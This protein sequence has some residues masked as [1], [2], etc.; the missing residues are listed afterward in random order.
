MSNMRIGG[1]ASG[2]D[3]DQIVGDLMKAERMPLDKLKQQKQV[4]EWQRDDYRSMNS[5][6]LNFRTELTNMKLTTQ[7]RARSVTSTNSELVTATASSAASQSSYTIKNVS[8]LASAATKVSA[9]SIA[10]TGQKV[11]PSKALLSQQGNL[12]GGAGYPWEN[13]SIGNKTFIADGVLDKFTI[14]K[15][16]DELVDLTKISDMTVKVNGKA[17]SIVAGDT[18]TTPA[19]ADQVIIDKNGNLKF[20]GPVAKDAK[21]EFNYVLDKKVEEKTL[22]ADTS[23]WQLGATFI[24]NTNFSL[25]ITKTDGTTTNYTLSGTADGDG[26][27]AL[28]DSGATRI[29][30]V[31][32]ETGKVIFDTAQTSGVTVKASYQQKYTSM[33][34]S[35]ETST[36]QKTEKFLISGSDT[37]NQVMN[38]VNS[39]NVGVTMF[40][41]SYSGN[42][43]LTRSETGN[44]SK[45]NLDNSDTAD[46][47]KATGFFATDLLKLSSAAT[48]GSNAM[49]NINGMNTSRSS[50]AFEM[51][52]V[53]FTLKQTFTDP[54]VSA[55]LSI[56]NDT[57]K[58]FDNIKAFVEKYNELIDKI[59]K[60][61]SEEY[62]RSYKPLTDEQRETL[63]EKQQEQWEE[64]AKSGLLKRDPILTGVL[65]GMRSN[66]YAPVR[67]A[68][69]DP[70]MNQLASIGIKTTANYLEGGKLEINEAALK[71]AIENNPESVENLFRG[72]G[73]TSDEQGIVHRLYDTVNGA[74]DKLK[75]RAGNT[76]STTK[77][78]TLG[79]QLDN[80]DSQINRFES[81]LTQVEDRYWRQFTAMEKAIQK[82]NS[83]SA[84]LMQQFSGG[85]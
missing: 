53:T 10:V 39:S 62:Y 1:L 20:S 66:F 34:L 61:S 58:V 78:F 83:Q 79:R 27:I 14:T 56:S 31:N 68:A 63:S 33:D 9:G 12:A 45:G 16:A 72:T 60:K 26:F 71:K 48:Y 2:M 23:E 44:F 47:I 77:Q 21:I 74:M 7:Y 43:S 76:F 13:G 5:L 17:Y 46:Q 24:N 84:Y 4:L 25:G 85:Y 65:G 11:D 73:T 55:S 19:S 30:R 15:H 36:G 29:G 38:K 51:N 40:F 69:V 82:A 32:L 59:Q 70:L 8:Q 42:V 64:K 41:D 75:A 50:N 49:F 81:R 28:V 80:V 37:L 22:S 54:A 35:T 3:I 52:G 6:L 67:N 57:N 18:T